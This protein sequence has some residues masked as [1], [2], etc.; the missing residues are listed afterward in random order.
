[1]TAQD[2]ERTNNLAIREMLNSASVLAEQRNDRQAADLVKE[3]LA[4]AE[5]LYGEEQAA[6]FLMNLLGEWT[7][8]ARETLFYAWNALEEKD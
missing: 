4:N 5:L 8:E 7:S 1:M 2:D 3:A 6:L